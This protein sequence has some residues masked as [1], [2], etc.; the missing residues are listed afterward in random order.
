[1]S[2]HTSNS[3]AR[4]GVIVWTAAFV[5]VVFIVWALLARGAT[6]GSA[7]ASRSLLTGTTPISTTSPQTYPRTA[8]PSAAS[9]SHA[10]KREQDPTT[11]PRTSVGIPSTK[12]DGPPPTT[13]P[14]PTSV[15]AVSPNQLATAEAIVRKFV[16][17][18]DIV[19]QRGSGSVTDVKPLAG[20]AALG[21]V[22]ASVDEMKGNGLH[23]RGRVDVLWVRPSAEKP[24]SPGSFVVGACIDSSA[25][26]LVDV[27]GDVV[28]GPARP[29][30]RLALTLYE[31]KETDSSAIVASSRF[32]NDTACT[33]R[34]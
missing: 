10:P 32:P 26:E 9:G 13:A 3:R 14:A 31:V 7:A 27:Q 22:Q 11:T 5:L 19:Y 18:S 28:R 23:Q 34:G 33:S 29:R 24:T 30:E 17:A 15:G 12:T 16:A 6:N 25:V 20:R 8:A 4:R 21:G 2:Q 1:M